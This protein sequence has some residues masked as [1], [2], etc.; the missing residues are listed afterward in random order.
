MGWFKLHITPFMVTWGWF[1]IGF[2]TFMVTWGWFMIEFATLLYR[3]CQI[4]P[5]FLLKIDDDC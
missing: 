3:I 2:A 4:L 1:M 5:D